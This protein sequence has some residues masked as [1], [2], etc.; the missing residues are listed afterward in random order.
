MKKKRKIWQGIL[1]ERNIVWM[2]NKIAK[3]KGKTKSRY[4]LELLEMDRVSK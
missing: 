1:I 4:L 3:K 2:F